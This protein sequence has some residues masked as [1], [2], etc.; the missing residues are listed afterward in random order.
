[1]RSLFL[2]LL[3]LFPS[4]L[5]A[6][7]QPV[8]SDTTYQPSY[9]S[10][11]H[12]DS[13]D[14]LL[15]SV[16]VQLEIT[17]GIDDLYNFNFPRAESQFRWLL[18]H[19]PQHPLPHYLMALSQW[20]KMMP[21]LRV[22]DYDSAFLVHIDRANGYAKALHKAEPDN[23]EAAFFL[24]AGHGLKG[25]FYSERDNWTQ[26]TL[27]GKRALKYMG[28]CRGNEDFSAE[29]LFGDGLYNYYYVWLW[30]E[31]TMLRPV[32][33]FFERGDQ[34]KGLEQLQTASRQAFYSRI[35]ALTFLLRIY[36]IEEKNY[37][38]ALEIANR[39][40]AAY[41]NNPYFHRYQARL[42]Y[43]LGYYSRLE[44]CAHEMLRRI[45]A[46]Q[47]GYGPN[48]GRYGAF[49]LGAL[50]KS[51]RRYPEAAAYY[52][53]V[54]LFAESIGAYESGYY[55]YAL[56]GRAQV[57]V[58]L[59]QYRYAEAIYRKALAYADRK[60]PVH[61]NAREFNKKYRKYKRK[62]VWPED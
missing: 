13:V 32:L 28:Q 33:F 48:T 2:L 45:E 23:L 58:T 60:H 55:L 54:I 46:G 47:P 51:R 50:Y 61:K 7:S 59:E 24:A 39:L 4:L 35:E 53:K 44:S 17:S 29:I 20:W 52:E 25:R 9:R 38:A 43:A 30:E 8:S 12:P 16:S 18:A 3:L 42:L 5:F 6:Q 11:P 62:G 19:Y 57:A 37:P 41:P 27:E 49:F 36:T 56:D 40:R 34:E 21:D 10:L 14:H 15:T 22:A 31:Y 1:M 26:A